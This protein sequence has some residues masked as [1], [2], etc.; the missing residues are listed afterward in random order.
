MT[1]QLETAIPPLRGCLYCH[2]EGTTVL[3]EGRKVLGLGDGFPVLRCT[4]C[5]AVALLDY[6]PAAPERWRIRYRHVNRASRYYY[7]AI[8]L[9]KGGWIDGPQAM[10]VSTDGFVQ[11]ARVQQVRSGDLA[12]LRPAPLDPPPPLMAIQEQ[13][14]LTVR[15]VVLQ[16]APPTG[17]LVRADQGPVLDAGTLY[18]TGSKLHLLGHRRDWSYRLSEVSR[19]YYDDHSWSVILDT[20]GQPQQYRGKNTL[21]DFDAQLIAAV[22]ETLSNAD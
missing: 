21:G 3:S 4:Q 8:Y 20:P 17:L 14:Y 1:A 18:V 6:D 7:V 22:I 10:A 5:D 2:A 13:V 12:W 9:G 19:V 11:R 16:E 15:G